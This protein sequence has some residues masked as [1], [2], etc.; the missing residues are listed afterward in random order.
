MWVWACVGNWVDEL[1]PPT[2]DDDGQTTSSSSSSAWRLGKG[3]AMFREDEATDFMVRPS[4]LCAT[5]WT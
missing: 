4:F 2:T 3:D 1:T 5:D